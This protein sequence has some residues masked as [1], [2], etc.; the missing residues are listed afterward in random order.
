MKLRVKINDGDSQFYA[1]PSQNLG[2]RSRLLAILKWCGQKARPAR[3]I[4]FGGEVSH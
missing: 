2:D 1:N 4:F 3:R